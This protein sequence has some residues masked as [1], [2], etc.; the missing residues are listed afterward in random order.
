[1]GYRQAR[2][3]EKLLVELGRK[4]RI[5]FVPPPPI[6]PT[7]EI[8]VPKDLLRDVV[9]LPGLSELQ[10]VRHFVRLSQM[11][12]AVDTGFYPLGSCTMKYNPKL[13]DRVASHPKVVNAHPHQLPE[14]VQG[15]L[16]M[17]YDLSTMLASITGTD[18]VTTLPAAGAHAE[19]LGALMIRKYHA[20]RGDEKRNEMIVPDSAHGTNP[21]SAQMAG[22]KVVKVS[23]DSRGLVDLE[24]LKKLLGER[25]AGMMMTVPNTLGLF[26]KDVITISKLV[27]EA[28]GLMYYDGANLNA[29]IGRVRPGDL[30]FDVVHLN[31]HKTFSTP[32]GGGGPGA[33]PLCVK[34]F[35]REYLPTPLLAYDGKLY[36]WEHE[37]PHSVGKVK[38]FWGNVGVLVRAYAYL[39]TLGPEGLKEVSGLS[40]LSSNYL[41]KKLDP[42]YYSLPYAE[43]VPRKHEFVV[44]SKPL[45]KTGVRALNVAKAIIDEGQHAPT[46]YFPLIVDEALMIEP[47]VTEPVEE[48]D[49]FADNLNEIGREAGDDPE[50]ILKRPLNNSSGMLDDFKASHPLSLRLRWPVQGKE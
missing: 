17:L 10:V 32:H 31:I 40:V 12:F 46:I 26:E 24:E 11:N 28:G 9:E 4:G 27:H 18:S 8:D 25:T 33:G 22:F 13:N 5:G 50:S 38:S 35:L 39:L 15:L 49:R 37:L 19:F 29:I 45:A 36:H 30:G 1:L 7:V 48:I 21:A 47:T 34:A 16:S 20:V 44:S 2:W 43:G 42:K 3:E 41:M 6:D 14:T 23:T